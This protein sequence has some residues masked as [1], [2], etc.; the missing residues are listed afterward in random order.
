M[1]YLVLC[2]WVLAVILIA[3]GLG[4]LGFKILLYLN[5]EDKSS[6]ECQTLGSMGIVLIVGLLI[7]NMYMGCLGV[8]GLLN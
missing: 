5:D 1:L 3:I 7:L 6:W 4:I 2:E 8:V